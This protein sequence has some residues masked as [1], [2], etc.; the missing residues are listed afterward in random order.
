[1]INVYLEYIQNDLDNFTIGPS[2][3]HGNGVICKKYILGGSFINNAILLTGNRIYTTNF[4][5]NLNHS[6]KPNAET[7]KEGNIYKT[8]AIIDINPGNEITV[9]YTKNKEL[10]E[11]PKPGWINS[12]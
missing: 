11:Q 6:I 4:G 7:R 5:T 8:Y 1:M 12:R 9:D 2:N 10:L 3:I